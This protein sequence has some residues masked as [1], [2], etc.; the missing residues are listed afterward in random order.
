MGLSTNHFAAAVTVVATKC[1]VARKSTADGRLSRG[2]TLHAKNRLFGQRPWD[3][4]PGALPRRSG[5][6]N[7]RPLA[8]VSIPSRC[9]YGKFRS[10]HTDHLP[11]HALEGEANSGPIDRYPARRAIFQF[12]RIARI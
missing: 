5:G 3:H 7:D 2:K 6:R 12:R 9:P 4:G 10:Q 8:A 1:G 11:D